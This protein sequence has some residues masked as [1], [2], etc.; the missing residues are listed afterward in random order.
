MPPEEPA[1]AGEPATELRRVKRRRGRRALANFENLPVTTHV[2]ELS[3]AERACPCCGEE[4]TRDRRG[5][6]LADRVPSRSLRA[7]AARAQEVRLCA[8]RSGGGEAAD[9][10][11]GA[12]GIAA[13]ERG[14]AGPGL[15]AYIVTS[16]FADY[17]PLYRLED[18]FARQGFEIA[19]ATQAVWCGDVADLV[20][21]LYRRMVERVR[22]SHVVATD[23]TVLPMLSA[24]KTQP[25]RMW[26]YVGDAAHPYN[27]FDFTLRRTRD[28]PQEFLQNFTGVLLADAYGGYNGVVAGNGLTR[29]GCWSHARQTLRRGGEDRAGNRPRG[30]RRAARVVCAR[31]AGQGT[32]RRRTFS[33]APGAIGAAPGRIAAEITALERTIAAQASHGRSRQL[34]LGPVGRTQRLLLGWGRSHR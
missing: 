18:I 4:R 25:A 5:R 8:L 30:G 33:P 27:V 31:T 12:G 16:K 11:G 10:G 20:E 15:L 6:E 26:V 3:G 2:Y 17:L 23:D 1:A 29:A 24:G 28:G 7:P 14:L 22:Q 34:H 9:A 21:P 19:R 13:I 32:F